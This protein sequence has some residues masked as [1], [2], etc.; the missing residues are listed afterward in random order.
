MIVV[1][2]P[3]RITRE[4][5]QLQQVAATGRGESESENENEPSEVTGLTISCISGAL[6]LKYNFNGTE[7]TA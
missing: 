4:D 3:T 5:Q 1:G 2:S 7:R 6:S